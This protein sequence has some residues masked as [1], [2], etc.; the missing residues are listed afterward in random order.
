MDGMRT[1]RVEGM[2]CEGCARAVTAAI[3]KQVPDAFVEV[4]VVAGCVRV[5]DEANE[6]AVRR[7]VERAGFT[8]HGAA[9][10]R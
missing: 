9:A 1:Y 2:T 4:D 8:W 3:R 10:G 5:G 7:A 6:D